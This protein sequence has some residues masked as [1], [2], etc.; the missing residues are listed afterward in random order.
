MRKVLMLRAGRHHRGFT[1]V[2]I[3]VVVVII[4]VLAAI[5]VPTVA[6]VQRRAR[7]TAVMNDFRVFAAA[8]D[9]YSHQNGTWPA[10]GAAGVVP[11]GMSQYLNTTA[12]ERTTPIGGKYNWE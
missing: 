4:S 8:F 7:T 11:A 2:E 6:R 9:T 10:E 3:M 5:A 1:L 12:W